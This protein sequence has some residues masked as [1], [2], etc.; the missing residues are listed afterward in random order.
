M[1]LNDMIKRQAE[2]DLTYAALADPTRR[3]IIARL[4]Q[5]PASVSE[6]AQ[7]LAMSLPAVTQHLKLLEQSG[8]VSSHKLGRV[9]TCRIEPARLAAAESWL[10][11]QRAAWSA[12][13]DRMDALLLEGK[14]LDG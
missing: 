9:R 7:P 5:G 6:L 14:E 3:A 12:R 13:F 2:L 10:A 8:F 11:G 4:A 1:T